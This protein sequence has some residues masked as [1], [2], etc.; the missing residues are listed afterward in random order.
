ME[1]R[2]CERDEFQVGLY[3]IVDFIIRPNKNNCK[4]TIQPNTNRIQVVDA[5][6]SNIQ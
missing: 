5:Q 2:I 4:L 6:L 3:R 1:E